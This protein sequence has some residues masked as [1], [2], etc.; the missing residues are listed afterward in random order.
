EDALRRDAPPLGDRSERPRVA[1]ALR[2]RRPVPDALLDGA[3][4]RATD[5]PARA[6]RRCGARRPA[7]APRALPLAVD[8]PRPEPHAPLL[9]M[10][11]AD[12]DRDGTRAERRLQE[13]GRGRREAFAEGGLAPSHAVVD[14][15][16]VRRL[17]DT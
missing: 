6:R 4:P 14:E 1:E 15:R 17:T 9:H 16:R 5:P 7:P 13:A 3:Q 11:P 10:P 2:P 12:L 8:H